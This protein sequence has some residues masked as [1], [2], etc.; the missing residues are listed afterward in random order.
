MKKIDIIQ[1]LKHLEG[2]TQNER[3]YF[4]TLEREAD[5]YFKFL[6]KNDFSTSPEKA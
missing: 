1:K 3:A 2:I 5:C 4:I 6:N